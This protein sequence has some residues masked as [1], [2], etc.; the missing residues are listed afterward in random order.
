[1]IQGLKI[2][3]KISNCLVSSLVASRAP[4]LPWQDW[5]S[6]HCAFSLLFF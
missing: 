2:A 4:R 5:E 1:M 3:L 6:I